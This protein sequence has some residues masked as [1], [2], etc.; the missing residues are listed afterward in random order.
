MSPRKKELSAMYHEACK[1][2]L[3]EALAERNVTEF[4]VCG[5][6]ISKPE[7]LV[8]VIDAILG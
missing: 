2:V 5:I 1:H 3:V 6:D 7:G 4:G 8:K